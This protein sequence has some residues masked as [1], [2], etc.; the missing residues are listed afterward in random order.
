M[1][2]HPTRSALCPTPGPRP[3][4]AGQVVATGLLGPEKCREDEYL[5]ELLTA[6]GAALMWPP[7]AQGGVEAQRQTAVLGSR[8]LG[9]FTAGS[10]QTGQ[11][12]NV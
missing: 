5:M 3:L 6:F 11:E 9:Q 7:D 8:A 2:R 1:G 10:P 12:E 4:R